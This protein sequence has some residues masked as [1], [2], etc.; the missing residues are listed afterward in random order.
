[1]NILENLIRELQRLLDS[2]LPNGLDPASDYARSLL[3]TV[4]ERIGLSS[5]VFAVMAAGGALLVYL[6]LTSIQRV[7]LEREYSRIEG[8]QH[9]SAIERLQFKLVQSGLRI[10][11]REFLLIGLLVGAAPGALFMLLGF[12]TIGGL[13]FVSGP[14]LYYQYLMNRRAKE[15]RQF[16]EDLPSAIL[17]CRDLLATE[18]DLRVVFQELTQSGPPGLRG[19]FSRALAQM[20]ALGVEG[21][22][23]STLREIGSSRPE[24]F[25]RQ[26]FYALA[27]ST[28]QGTDT[29][30][31][32]KRIAQG[33]KVQTRLQSRTRAKQAGLRIV[34]LI[35]LFA[36]A[37][38]A[39]W[40]SLLSAD[41]TGNFYQTWTGQLVQVIAVGLGVLS[42]WGSMRIAR[43]G[44]YLDEMVGTHVDTTAFP[45]TLIKDEMGEFV[46]DEPPSIFATAGGAT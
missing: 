42:Y 39:L 36:P 4:Q 46:E 2:L 38:A 3:L 34:A 26:F 30:E 13:F 12:L 22:L 35:Y 17:D 44:L 10:H 37:G 7:S 8:M 20:T 45:S 23:A 14:F 41:F 29:R 11:A 32:L 15:L 33:Q 21:S 25:F 18:S 9:L 19:E 40:T 6:G 43:R 28:T 1:M 24:P 31:V 16:R 5:V 27:N